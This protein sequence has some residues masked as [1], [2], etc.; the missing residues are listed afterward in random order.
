EDVVRRAHTR[1]DVV[2]ADDAGLRRKDDGRREKLHRTDLLFREVTP[3]VLVPKSP[4]QRQPASRPLFLPI[5]RFV[6]GPLFQ[7]ERVEIHR[8]L[9]WNA[10]VEAINQVRVIAEIISV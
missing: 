10:V 2:V 4:L 9:V 6:P 8:E 5:E 1:G 3:R 7:A